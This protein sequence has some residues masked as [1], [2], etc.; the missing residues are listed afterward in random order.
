MLANMHMMMFTAAKGIESKDFSTDDE[1]IVAKAG[2]RMSILRHLVSITLGCRC[3]TL[4]I[5]G[6]QALALIRS[7]MLRWVRLGSFHYCDTLRI[8][9]QVQTTSITGLTSCFRIL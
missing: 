6:H 3:P 4:Y 1:D 9:L 8:L 7:A 2:P 5:P